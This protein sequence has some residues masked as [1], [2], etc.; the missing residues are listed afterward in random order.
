LLRILQRRKSLFIGE[1]TTSESIGMFAKVMIRVFV[2]V[3]LQAPTEEDTQRLMKMNEK[4]GWPGMLLI[5]DCM[6]WRWINS[7]GLA[8]VLLR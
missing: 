2:P 1:D 7:E 6:N 5:I 4:R 8:W 3:Y